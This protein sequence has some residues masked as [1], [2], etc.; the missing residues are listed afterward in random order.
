MD[1][2]P[3]ISNDLQLI[4]HGTE[5]LEV[6]GSSQLVVTQSH[7]N[8][9]SEKTFYKDY[10]GKSIDPST[11]DVQTDDHPDDNTEDLQT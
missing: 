5:D 10:S 8:Y 1:T 3:F 7:S 4:A 9:M 6:V 11:A 2:V